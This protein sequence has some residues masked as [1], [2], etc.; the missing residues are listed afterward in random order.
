[1]VTLVSCMLTNAFTAPSLLTA[2]SLPVN[3]VAR[4]RPSSTGGGSSL[5]VLSI[6]I[7]VFT[8]VEATC[9]PLTLRVCHV[10]YRL[11]GWLFRF[12]GPWLPADIDTGHVG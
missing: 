3:A 4:V 7:D 11:E 2:T 1:M 8:K 9:W 12:K 6:E 10:I 5:A